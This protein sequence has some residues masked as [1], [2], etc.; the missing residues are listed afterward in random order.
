MSLQLFNYHLPKGSNF[1]ISVFSSILEFVTEAIKQRNC[2]NQNLDEKERNYTLTIHLVHEFTFYQCCKLLPQFEQLQK[3]F[4]ESNSIK[5]KVEN[6]KEQFKKYFFSLWKG[7]QDEQ[8]SANELASLVFSS[9]SCSA[10]NVMG[11]EMIKLFKES[12]MMPST[13]YQI[14]LDILKELCE[15]EDFATYMKYIND[16]FGYTSE[17]FET[18][19]EN[20]YTRVENVNTILEKCDRFYDELMN[21]AINYAGIATDVITSR[22]IQGAD[23]DEIKQF[24]KTEFLKLIQ[25]R[26]SNI[27]N[28]TLVIF[29]AYEIESYDTFFRSFRDLLREKCTNK[30]FAIP[31][32]FKSLS[33]KILDEIIQCRECCPL[34]NEMC[35]RNRVHHDHYCNVFHRPLG[36]YGVKNSQNQLVRDTCP[37]LFKSKRLS[38]FENSLFPNYYL[39][40]VNIKEKHWKIDS[41]ESI[42]T[43]YWI[44]VLNRFQLEFESQYS[45]SPRSDNNDIQFL[46]KNE[47][48]MA[49]S[50]RSDQ[51]G[52]FNYSPETG[53]IQRKIPKMF[54]KLIS[55]MVIKR[56]NK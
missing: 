41:K 46:S 28:T 3:D 44:W 25:P 4:Q 47:I 35:Q 45:A 29:D 39:S 31:N 7:V 18:R 30:V 22:L 56:K 52:N 42:D 49:L 15:K 43:R 21:L 40:E 8:C 6:K 20:Y 1:S 10:K 54:Q 32:D 53:E 33:N 13:K 27:S 12:N 16:P 51:F 34:C 14:Q 24:W 5:N 19:M 26:V 55:F 38:T 36:V 2:E 48:L 11:E 17:W 9:I 50:N 23:S 37:I